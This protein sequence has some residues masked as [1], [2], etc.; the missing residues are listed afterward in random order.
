MASVCA[1][2]STPVVRT[3]HDDVRLDLEGLA[4][5]AEALLRLNA[6]ARGVSGDLGRF[7]CDPPDQEPAK[8][9]EHNDLLPTLKRLRQE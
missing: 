9:L 3:L 6:T 2:A 7:L 5:V 1:L 4:S 8:V